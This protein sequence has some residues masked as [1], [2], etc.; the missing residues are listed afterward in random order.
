MQGS[1]STSPERG[2]DDH[3]PAAGT[4]TSRGTRVHA[5]SRLARGGTDLA[6]TGKGGSARAHPIW[7]WVDSES[8]ASPS[9]ARAVA[10]QLIIIPS[11]IIAAGFS[12]LVDSLWSSIYVVSGS[13]PPVE[14]QGKTLDGFNTYEYR[15]EEQT[16]DP[17]N[18]DG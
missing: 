5:P 18:P 10:D 3:Q 13:H 12:N 11:D 4:T 2:A 7:V 6:I 8:E 14:Y 17:N 9:S 15:R 1:R 16:S